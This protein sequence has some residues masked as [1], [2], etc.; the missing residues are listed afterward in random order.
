MIH[1]GVHDAHYFVPV[2]SASVYSNIETQNATEDSPYSEST[3]WDYPQHRPFMPLYLHQCLGDYPGMTTPP[4]ESIDPRLLTIDSVSYSDPLDAAVVTPTVRNS[5]ASVQST[6]S[7]SDGHPI[8]LPAQV[9]SISI[10]TTMRAALYAEVDS[11][12]TSS[13]NS[14][15]RW[16][17]VVQCPLCHRLFDRKSRAQACEN[18]HK[19]IGG[20]PCSGTCGNTNW[21]VPFTSFVS[22]SRSADTRT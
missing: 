5:T 21:S 6:L 11:P 13:H 3:D 9:D 20:Y 10:D 15:G 17:K 4:V 19:G 22:P 14:L 16:S 8:P 7:L 1:A 18:K 12:S 2:S